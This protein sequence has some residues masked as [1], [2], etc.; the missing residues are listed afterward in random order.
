M[1]AATV[2]HN[3]MHWVGETTKYFAAALVAAAGTVPVR[4]PAAVLV[5]GER[6]GFR[7]ARCGRSTAVARRGRRTW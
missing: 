1:R 5:L 4:V 6:A 2:R 3:G 7:E